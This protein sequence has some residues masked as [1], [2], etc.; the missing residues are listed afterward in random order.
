[1]RLCILAAIALGAIG[2]ADPPTADETPR[3]ADLFYAAEESAAELANSAAAEWGE[4]GFNFLVTTE[5]PAGQLFSEI[6]I[7]DRVCADWPGTPENA[8]GC[9]YAVRQTASGLLRDSAMT[10]RAQGDEVAFIVEIQRGSNIRREILHELGHVAGFCHVD[11]PVVMHSVANA[12][13]HLTSA[14]LSHP[15]D[16]DEP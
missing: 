1:M 14:D 16:K 8:I 4:F 3:S 12:A 2:C 5:K 9:A 6:R 13:E 7:V 15:C 10:A 11:G